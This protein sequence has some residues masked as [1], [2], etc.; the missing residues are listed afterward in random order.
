MKIVY[1]DRQIEQIEEIEKI[2]RKNK[3]PHYKVVKEIIS[4]VNHKFGD[5]V[6]LYV[7]T[8]TER[9]WSFH[10][11]FNKSRLNYST[12][13]LLGYDGA[14]MSRF[15]S[16]IESVRWGEIRNYASFMYR[17]SIGLLLREMGIDICV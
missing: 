9:L 16:P 3:T 4:E 14:M 10:F 12:K 6:I 17:E 1:R 2:E 15:E 7:Y 13:F 5:G 8:D 11:R